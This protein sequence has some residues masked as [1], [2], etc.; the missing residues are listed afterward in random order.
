MPFFDHPTCFAGW[1][2]STCI[3][4]VDTLPKSNLDPTPENMPSPKERIVS[5]PS[6]SERTCSFQGGYLKFSSTLA[7]VKPGPWRSQNRCSKEFQP[8][9]EGRIILGRLLKCYKPPVL[10]Y[11]SCYYEICTSTYGL[12]PWTSEKIHIFAS[13]LVVWWSS[14]WVVRIL[15]CAIHSPKT[16]NRYFLW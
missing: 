1:L 6:I 16:F 2:L 14:L 7:K 5:R 12:Y 11:R 13:H 3:V 10:K 15:I 9:L 4:E 8:P